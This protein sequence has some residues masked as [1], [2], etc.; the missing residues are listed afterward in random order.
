MTAIQGI[1]P[2]LSA[3]ILI[4]AVGVGIVRLWLW[5]RSAPVERRATPRRVALLAV[6][7]ALVGVLLFLTLHPPIAALGNATML[8]ATRNTPPTAVSD[9][10]ILVALPEAGA[11]PKAERVPDLAT[12]IR[13]HPE[14]ARVRVLGEGL[15]PRDR[16]PLTLPVETAP[17]PHPPGF[18]EIALPPAVAP[19]AAFTVGGLVGTLG[20]GTVELVDPAGA[21]IARVPI[22]SGRRF[23]LSGAA[24]A[25]GM[26]VFELRL[27]AADGRLVE[28]LDVPLHTRADPPP[29]VI[30][31]AGAPG[32]EMNFLRRWAASAGVDLSI[33]MDLGSGI[34]LGQAPRLTSA[35]LDRTDLLVID[36]RSWENLDPSTH[37]L[38]TG[39]VDGGMGLLLRPTA[40][41][42]GGTRREWAV[43][44][45]PISGD[46]AA[47]PLLAAEGVP[48][49]V[50]RNLA[51]P[52]PDA[53]SVVHAPDGSPLAG[54]RLRGRGRIG[55]WTVMDSYVIALAGRPDAHADLWS[56]L[57]SVLGR[58]LDT[59]RPH[60]RGLARVGDR[61][62]V[63]GVTPRDAVSAPDGR[64]TR[65][66]IDP[67]AGVENCAAF[68]PSRAGWNLVSSPGGLETPVYVHPADAAPSLRAHDAASAPGGVAPKPPASAGSGAPLAANLPLVALLLLFAALWI[69]ERR[70][71]AGPPR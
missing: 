20:A 8:V 19:G 63:C 62:V 40:A 26:A 53:V 43:L 54:W 44:G 39:A 2:L 5:Q 3:A 51:D 60:L 14:A 10:E 7:Q 27:R 4:L 9:G 28:R 22:A 41:L 50:R 21:I 66:Q 30:A 52:G 42:T 34:R 29:R 11:V 46:G 24:R 35:E 33:G 61:A 48:D 71:P 57:F 65:L 69:S 17:T 12:A 59:D 38:V 32:P 70:R 13:R 36:D 23:T 31:L 18:V 68:W 45:A 64:S 47:N 16:G 56:D 58:P 15:P 25:E 1:S 55:V 37:S 49:L 67:K 6:L